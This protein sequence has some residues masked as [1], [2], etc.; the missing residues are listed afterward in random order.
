MAIKTRG[1]NIIKNFLNVV[2]DGVKNLFHCLHKL[3]KL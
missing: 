1:K 2:F 3:V